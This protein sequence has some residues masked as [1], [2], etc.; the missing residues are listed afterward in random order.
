M[1]GTNTKASR[2]EK[3]NGGKDAD[4]HERVEEDVPLSEDLQAE[5][6][7]DAAFRGERKGERG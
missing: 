4:T 3:R 1:K 5:L 2:L 6:G 7:P